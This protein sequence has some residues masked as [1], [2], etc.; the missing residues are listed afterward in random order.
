MLALMA[1][2]AAVTFCVT[3][4]ELADSQAVSPAA[5]KAE[6]LT[7]LIDRYFIDEY[8]ETIL[9]DGAAAGMIAATGDQ[10]SYYISAADYRA[11]MEQM[12]NAYVGIG[13]TI[14]EDAEAGGF[15]IMSVVEGGPA[16]KGGVQVDDVLIEV[17]GQNALELGQD[18]TVELVRGRE[19]TEI[20]LLFLRD[21]QRRSVTLTRESVA[22]VVVSYR[23]EAGDIAV[24]T[25]LNFDSHSAQDTIAAVERAVSEGARGIVFDVRNNPGGMK[26]ELVK[27][28]DRIL[29]EGDLFRSVDYEGKEEVDTSDAE[30]LDL[31]MAVL[32][33]EES[34]S[35]AEFFAA[36]LQEYGAAEVVGM[37]TSGKGNYQSTFRLSDGS[38]AALSIGRY[39]T[40]Q[41]RSL[42]DV[43]VTPDVEVDLSD[44]D[45]AR[46]YYDQ[47][48]PGEDA[49]LQAALALLQESP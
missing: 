34:Y 32:V 38:A 10:W 2:S 15:R 22:T 1:A 25:I 48:P 43:G 14:E 9:S 41:G 23:M 30:C 16:D 3:Y 27:I 35:A 36:A 33:N 39:F 4:R 11:Y 6:E 12:N 17:E 7:A 40:P 49:Q 28:L 26:D 24:I 44:E 45:F 42:T 31:P 29:P 47:L 18:A 21:G 46:L 5:V 37:P 13:V 8:D 19:G 20:Q